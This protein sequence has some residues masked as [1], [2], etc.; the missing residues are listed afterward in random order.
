MDTIQNFIEI[1]HFINPL[2][3]QCFLSEKTISEF[4]EEADGEVS[5]RFI[6]YFNFQILN[7]QLSR[8]HRRKTSLADRNAIYNDAY[9]ASLGFYAAS[10]QG[11]KWG[12]K[13]LM[14]LQEKNII[15]RENIS[16][17]V[18]NNVASELQ[19]D[20]EMFQEDLQSDCVKKMF[21][22]DQKL[23][24]EMEVEKTPTCIVYT[25]GDTGYLIEDIIQKETLHEVCKSCYTL[26][27]GSEACEILPFHPL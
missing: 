6:P 13:F 22:N 24:H 15:Y 17:S 1:Y 10:T 18:I 5:I 7:L 2:G 8:E 21:V 3:S 26:Q 27:D 4:A 23:A 25:N 14:A 19:L 12:R 11:K 16:I 9:M 20:F